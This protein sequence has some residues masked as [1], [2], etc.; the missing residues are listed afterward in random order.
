MKEF[1]HLYAG[2]DF[3][4]KGISV[5]QG[6]TIEKPSGDDVLAPLY[7]VNPLEPNLNVARNV[8]EDELL[9]FQNECIKALDDLEHSTFPRGTRRVSGNR[10]GLAELCISQHAP[11]TPS[12]EATVPINVHL[13][14]IFVDESGEEILAKES[15]DKV[16]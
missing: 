4:N 14:S 10:W 7:M 1:F 9:K 8:Q 3:K 11:E 16:S 6:K 2:F 15:S 13:N 5:L 12:T